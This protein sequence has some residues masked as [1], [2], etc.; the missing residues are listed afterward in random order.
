MAGEVWEGTL[1][2]VRTHGAYGPRDV[3]VIAS[4]E[5][6]EGPDIVPRRPGQ[7]SPQDQQRLSNEGIPEESWGD[8]AKLMEERYR[9]EG[10]RF[11]LVSTD[12]LREGPTRTRVMEKIL[13]V[14]QST[15]KPGGE[16]T[17]E[18]TTI[19]LNMHG[20]KTWSQISCRL[21]PDLPSYVLL[22]GVLIYTN[23]PPNSLPD[24]HFL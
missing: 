17:S 24:V 13:T 22:P 8:D 3:L 18:L 12:C 14:M 15:T 5:G 16:R 19:G 6:L 11:S 1:Q 2:G 9:R 4:S 7:L 21:F 10:S 20:E 23:F